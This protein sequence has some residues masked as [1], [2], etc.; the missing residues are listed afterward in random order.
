MV[1]REKVKETAAAKLA[2]KASDVK[3]GFACHI[4]GEQLDSCP[5]LYDHLNDHQKKTTYYTCPHCKEK[6]TDFMVCCEHEKSHDKNEFIC[7]ECRLNC[8]HYKNVVVCGKIHKFPCQM[9]LQV[10]NSWDELKNHMKFL[11]GRPIPIYKCSICT[12]AAADLTQYHAHFNRMHR[13]FECKYCLSFNLQSEVDAH[14]TKEHPPRQESDPINTAQASTSAGV[15][16]QS[17]QT[18]QASAVIDVNPLNTAEG[19]TVQPLGMKLRQCPVCD[20]YFGAWEFMQDHINKYH[21]KMLVTCKYCKDTV[22]SPMMSGHMRDSH[23][24]CFS[25]LKSFASDNLLQEHRLECRPGA[26][27]TVLLERVII[28]PPEPPQQEQPPAPPAPPVPAPPAPAPPAPVSEV[29]EPVPEPPTSELVEKPKTTGRPG[30]PGR[31]HVCEHCGKDFEK[32]SSL[33]MHESQKH[34]DKIDPSVL[35]T[36]VTCDTCDRTFA[37]QA[38]LEQHAEAGHKSQPDPTPA[39]PAPAPEPTPP[40][41]H[42]IYCTVDN[43][44]FF[45]YIVIDL[46]KHRRWDHPGVYKFKC[47]RCPYVTDTSDKIGIHNTLVHL[48]GYLSMGDSVYLTCSLCTTICFSWA[49][50]FAHIRKHPTNKY[51]CN[52]CQWV[53]N[54]PTLLNKHCVST[55]DTRHKVVVTV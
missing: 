14:V 33:H 46:Q 2:G 49:E 12:F 5:E 13:R 21:F 17:V 6:F 24:T 37:S 10:F 8:K 45:C 19:G 11:H 41:P 3:I 52:E 25:Y 47:N 22:F 28:P 1:T 44:N 7:C 18:S 26:K 40:Q 15:S 32:L 29:P 36:P 55:H 30:H 43:C 20:M 34:R 50:F 51:P 38:D 39:P 31:P 53:F 23:A 16:S 35:N 54:S 27:Y 9:C 48:G 4:C 42:H